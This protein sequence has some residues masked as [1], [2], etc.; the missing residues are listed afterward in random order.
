MPWRR[1]ASVNSTCPRRASESGAP[2]PPPAVDSGLRRA[3]SQIERR[4]EFMLTKE[5]N[6]LITLTGPDTLGGALM[7]CYWHPIALSKEL[8][9]NGA[10]LPVRLLGEDLVL[11]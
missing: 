2:S 11:F 8:P 4:S 6:A 1:S 7:R 10:P 9:Q 5:E 3:L